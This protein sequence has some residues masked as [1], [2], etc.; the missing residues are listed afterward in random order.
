[1]TK[2]HYEMLAEAIASA[3]PQGMRLPPGSMRVWERV[4]RKVSD[5]L[6]EDNP[7]FDVQRFRDAC[8]VDE[9]N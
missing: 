6:A 3:K 9:Y 5:A 4:V 7:R 8:G 2:K 1:M